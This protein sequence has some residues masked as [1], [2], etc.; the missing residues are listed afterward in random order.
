MVENA[1][2]KY[3]SDA[4]I[5]E[6]P[7][8]IHGGKIVGIVDAVAAALNTNQTVR[9]LDLSDTNVPDSDLATLTGVLSKNASLKQLVMES[10]RISEEGIIQFASALPRMPNLRKLNLRQNKCGPQVCDA[11]QRGL[12][13]GNF[14]L[15]V[16]EFEKGRFDGNCCSPPE[17]FH[18]CESKCLLAIKCLLA[19]NRAGRSLLVNNRDCTKTRVPTSLWPYVF[20]RANDDIHF[21]KDIIF[22]LLRAQA[23]L[24]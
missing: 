1:S 17:Y 10:C 16:L 23:L 14:G 9:V 3:C 13:N 6:V 2:I 8:T 15:H 4:G 12:E 7:G 5:A 22:N 24:S 21:S 19:V 18:D 11:L 20:E